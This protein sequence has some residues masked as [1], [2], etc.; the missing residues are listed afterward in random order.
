MV[1]ETVRSMAPCNN[2]SASNDQGAPTIDP[3]SPYYVHPSDGPT[4]IPI[5]PVL[6]GSNYHSWARSMRRALGLEALQYA[7]S[8]IHGS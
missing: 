1:L 3:S 7:C 2:A 4:S 5:T 6:T 8:C